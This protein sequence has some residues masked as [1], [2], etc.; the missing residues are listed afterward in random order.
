MRLLITGTGGT[1]GSAVRLAAARAGHTAIAWDRTRAEPS[2]VAAGARLL[3][4]ERPDA[5]LALAVPSQ[6]TGV[7]G[8]SW[9]V[10]GAWPA[11]LA[12]A[13]ARRK[14]PFVYTSTVMVYTDRQPGPYTPATIPAPSGVYGAEK[15]AGERAVTGANPRAIVARLGWQIGVAPGGNHMYDHLE[16]QFLETGVVRASARWLPAC[17]FVEDTAAELLRLVEADPG[18]YLLDGNRGWSFLEIARAID[19]EHGRRWRIEEDSAYVHDQRMQDA[20]TRTASL[21][22]RLHELEPH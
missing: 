1:V 14:I 20:R 8:E 16:R 11:R 6:P 10:N 22:D 7:A 2:A 9:L 3:D 4:E 19:A 17:S 15:L 13:A 21:R 5:I 12:R 18:T